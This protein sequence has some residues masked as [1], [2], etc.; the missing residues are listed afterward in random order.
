M[1]IV[2]LNWMSSQVYI[3]HLVHHL[4]TIGFTNKKYNLWKRKRWQ[5]IEGFNTHS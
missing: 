2:I 4:E 5:V 3:V 1:V